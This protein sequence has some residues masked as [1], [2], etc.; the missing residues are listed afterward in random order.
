M[1][2]VVYED[3]SVSY[4][5]AVLLSSAMDDLGISKIRPCGGQGICGKCKV[6]ANGREVLSCRTYVSEDTYIDSIEDE[7][8]IQGLIYGYMPSV[9]G[10]PLLNEGYALVMDIG[11]TTV[12]GYVYKFPEGE[13]VSR[14]A[15]IN[16]QVKY[17]A[18]VISRIEFCV[19]GGLETLRQ[20]IQ[21]VK[22]EL[23]DGK[24]IKKCV[25]TGNT[26][27]LHIFMGF[28]PSGLATAP[29]LPKSLF[30]K[31]YG[32]FYLPRSIGAYV[33]ADITAGILAS[34]MCD[35]K[36]AFLVDIGTNGEMVLLNKGRLVCCSA[37]AGPAFEGAGISMGMQA[38][39]GAI[40]KV[41]IKGG[42]VK[43]TTI[44]N[45]KPKGIC[46]SGL[47]DAIA[48]MRELWVIDKTGFMEDDF[49]IG[50]SGIFITKDDVRAVQLAKSAIRSGIDTLLNNADV[51][52][53]EIEA[54]YIAGGFGSYI[55]KESAAK[56][57]L[58]P[59]EVLDKAI[60]IGNA[61]LSGG[62]MMLKSKECLERS[63]EIGKMATEIPLSTDAYFEKKYIE[64]M[65]F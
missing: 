9:G 26:A 22:E 56:I 24:K 39:P 49:E 25:I 5:K 10:E 17:G 20:S 3:K 51:S 44:D 45:Q 31:W 43:Y 1:F 64:N 65:M 57:G 14:K 2:K 53:S 19:S 34:G 13:C 48:C 4:D 60:V 40:D 30:G 59:S 7:T 62:V 16:P 35:K 38:L 8:D 11:T 55:D 12:A 36:T 33:G 47:I 50:D 41:Y 28:E 42:E 27:M 46:G 58:I 54:F 32:D 52:L 6:I 63:E 18:D 29:F 23:S 21:K 61:S 15:V 37:P